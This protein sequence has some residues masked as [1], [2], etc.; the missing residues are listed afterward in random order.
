MDILKCWNESNILS[1]A[2]QVLLQSNF[3]LANSDIDDTNSKQPQSDAPHY[4]LQCL[5]V[6]NRVN[7]KK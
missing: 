7:A 2:V 1:R 5:A 3:Y 4:F 6:S